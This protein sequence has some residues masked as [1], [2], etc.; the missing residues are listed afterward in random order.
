[1]PK[2]TVSAVRTYTP[3]A[4]RREIRDTLGPGLYLVIQA[5]PSGHKS[6]ALRFRRPDGR[7]AKLTLGP[8]ELS[9]T[10]TADDPVL[11]GALTLRQARQLANQIDRERARG[12]DVIEA[13]KA[14]QSR[15]RASMAD[16]AANSFAT[17]VREFFTDHKTKW[18]TRPR[19][20][21][22]DAR[23]LGLGYPPD[24]DPAETEPEVI[25]GSLAATWAD[26]AIADID[27]HDI[28]TVV[29]E[30]RKLG[31]PG[32]PRR[33]G[34]TSEAR[35]R[36]MHAALSVL[37]KWALQRRKVVVNPTVGVWHPG[38]PPARERVLSEAE[39]ALFWKACEHIGWPF[40]PLFQQLLLT[41]ARLAEVTGMRY[42]ELSEGTWT[43]PGE[44]TKNHRT[45][46]VPLPPLARE[47]ISRVPRIE[48]PY[49]FT[50]NGKRPVTG[51]SKAKPQLDRA[52][53]KLAE[54]SIPPWRLHDLRRTCATGMQ[55]LGIRVEVIE[56]VL[57]HLSGSFRG[58]AGIYQRDPMDAD[59]RE[60]LER[61]AVHVEGLVSARPANV[62]SLRRDAS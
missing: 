30:A 51:F 56:R 26:N 24:C 21:R 31:I 12:I 54:A 27:G 40:G 15:Q 42:D 46:V 59:K 53:A 29:D 14:R 38:A 35:G 19:R 10:E 17:V 23:L 55:R 61:W 60:A 48:G 41:G 22:A 32:L 3:Q 37:F 13:Y 47:I 6:W 11:G 44:R 1:M 62:V 8:V 2:L 20:W 5:K 58:V 33:N 45:H 57:N 34:G 39:I 18:H 28:F 49:V 4:K 7:P 50:T 16:R 52:M 36:K 25:T 43:I 9:D